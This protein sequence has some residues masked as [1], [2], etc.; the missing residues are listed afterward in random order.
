M[1]VELGVGFLAVGAAGYAIHRYR[2]HV[3]WARIREEEVER[4]EWLKREMERGEMKG[5]KW[6]RRKAR[7]GK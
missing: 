1:I 3:K 6:P 2:K 5:L 7:G 4:L